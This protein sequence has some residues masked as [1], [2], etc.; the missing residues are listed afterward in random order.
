MSVLISFGSAS[1]RIGASTAARTTIASQ[2]IDKPRAEAELPL[3]RGANSGVGDDGVGVLDR[4]GDCRERFGG[5]HGRY[6][7]A[8]ACRIRGSSTV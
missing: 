4:G 3:L 6:P 1:G 8:R 7:S 2:A 5:A